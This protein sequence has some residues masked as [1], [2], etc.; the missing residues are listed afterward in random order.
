MHEYAPHAPGGHLGGDP[1]NVVL[2]AISSFFDGNLFLVLRLVLG[3]FF[4]FLRFFKVLWFWRVFMF[5]GRILALRTS[6]PPIS[7]LYHLQYL[8][9]L[10]S[11]FRELLRLNSSGAAVWR[12]EGGA[13]RFVYSS[14]LGGLPVVGSMPNRWSGSWD[15]SNQIL[16]FLGFFLLLRLLLWLEH[17]AD[18]L[19]TASPNK[20]EA[21]GHLM[22]RKYYA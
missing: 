1:F 12:R 10:I 14:S 9:R 8:E 20:S 11:L 16:R 5:F 17:D 6:F 4:Y 2:L 3:C 15:F 13:T 21:D 22:V 18:G 19:N 7:P